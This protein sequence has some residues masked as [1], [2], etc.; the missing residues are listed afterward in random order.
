MTQ[1]IF[2][3]LNATQ[4]LNIFTM[5]DRN[6]LLANEDRYRYNIHYRSSWKADRRKEFL[7]PI[8]SKYF[9]ERINDL[10]GM[11]PKRMYEYI[12]NTL[13]PEMIRPKPESA[14][15]NG[16]KVES[17]ISVL[18]KQL[19]AI[20][21][22][23]NELKSSKDD[24]EMIDLDRRRNKATWLQRDLLV[25][26]PPPPPPTV[27]RYVD[28]PEYVKNK[29]EKAVKPE[30]F[31]KRITS[32][33]VVD[34]LINRLYEKPF[35]TEIPISTL[36][37]DQ[38]A[39][40]A[41]QLRKWFFANIKPKL[42]DKM[43]VGFTAGLREVRH[44]V[45]KELERLE[46]MFTKNYFFDISEVKTNMNAYDGDL[47]LNMLDAI[48]FYDFSQWVEKPNSRRSVHGDGFF[49]R[50]LSGN[51]VKLEEILYPFQIYSTYL[52]GNGNVKK[53][54]HTPCF[55]NALRESG[56]D[57]KICDEILAFVGYQSR[58][59]RNV[60]TEIAQHFD[61]AI[62]LR[63]YDAKRG[64]IDTANYNNKGWYNPNGKN[65][66]Y[67][68]EYLDHV[69]VDKELPI[70]LF[71]IRNWDK[72]CDK[73]DD[74]NRL[75]KTY[76]V[77]P[78]GTIS[79]D[80]KKANA[81]SLDVIIAI[82]KAGGFENINGSDFDVDK[83]QIFSHEIKEPKPVAGPYNEKLHTRKIV[84]RKYSRTGKNSQWKTLSES[85]YSNIYYADF[86]TCKKKVDG[87]KVHAEAVPFMLCLSSEGGF[88]TKTYTGIDCMTQMFNDVADNS[89]VYFHNL[90]FDG[91]FFMKYGFKQIIKKGSKII[92]M[93][94][95]Y[96]G[97]NI[98][99]KDSFSLFPKALKS[100]PASFPLSFKG[101]NVQ[102]EL[103]PYDYYTFD[104]IYVNDGNKVV[105][106]VDEAIATT[107]WNEEEINVFKK[108]ITKMDCWIDREQGTF[109]M[110]KYCEFYC[111]QDV[112]VLRIG[113]NAFVEAAKSEPIKMNL[114]DYLTLPA[115]AN[116]YLTKKVFV[117]NK[118]VYELNGMVQKFIQQTVYG[119]RC[120]T[121]NNRRYNIKGIK[122]ADF[123]AC[124]LYPSAMRRMFAVEGTPEFYEHKDVDMIYDKNN[125]PDILIHAFDEDQMK[126][127][128]TR[129]IS[130]FFVEIEI[131]KVGIHR[132]F[133]LIIKRENGKQTNCNGP[134][135]SASTAQGAECV[136]MVVDMITLQD[137]ITFQD[138]SFKLGNGYIMKGNR[139]HSVRSV[140]Q[141]LFDLRA[142]YKKEKN[143]TQEVIKLIM[144]SA[145][146]KTIQKPI[147]T[148]LQFVKA[149]EFEWF[150]QNR[151]HQIVKIDK[152]DGSDMYLFELQK[153]KAKQFNNVVFGT[154]VLSMSK[155]I[156]NEVMCLAEDLGIKIWYQD[157]DS[158]HIEADKVSCLNEAFKNKYGRELIGE[159]IMGCFHS[160]FDEIPD[161]VAD[162]HISLGKKMYYD[163]LVNEQGDRSEHYRMKGIPQIVIKNTAD[164]LFNSNIQSLY[165]YLFE[166]NSLTFDC[167]DGRVGFNFTRSGKIEYV[168]NFTRKVS[169]TSEL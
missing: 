150:V 80:N 21:K 55:I 107:T 82:D 143:P 75:L 108:N 127:T 58:I 40:L 23:I 97:K 83:A 106:N 87:K 34:D 19:E 18:T 76:K 32:D 112:N 81:R 165:E 126:P 46:K 111:S 39:L 48:T 125:L 159:N 35:G 37:D 102:K 166:G 137:L 129:Y 50:K 160:D 6:N 146:G 74:I 141:N 86:E 138:I 98:N 158:M 66:I 132:Q 8:V 15:V 45:Q 3:K 101:L 29:L 20:K 147:K 93:K 88:M 54:V 123:D 57:K 161:A 71:A 136:R 92:S 91:N 31:V 44:T 53:N 33:K 25:P 1:R 145:Y 122:I 124:S 142:Q 49:P 152:V 26:P 4:L 103:F 100:F 2:E 47:Y 77:R 63:I 109:D 85:T 16:P 118:N 96:N 156:M 135:Q 12:V 68:A 167:L 7:V 69:F 51:Y 65:K 110:M 149:D 62:H 89:I 117:P 56:V 144:N 116:A 10:D 128:A 73:C 41:P 94:A 130:Q 28:S 154:T 38:L 52:N 11:T 78:D 60:W 151:Y 24:S 70:N 79:I 43:L 131:V 67:L 84:D 120:M 169:P 163:R 168:A 140:I 104:R 99:F 27:E 134:A 59:N 30:G 9:E 121:A 95:N 5:L 61:L 105:G 119:G 115:L 64:K 162:V 72:I 17:E 148:Y 155:R 164:K 157:T 90:G 133:P 153:M 13:I 36:S 113:F 42:N 14:T 22:R 139:D 114:H